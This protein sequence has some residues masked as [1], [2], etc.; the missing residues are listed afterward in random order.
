MKYKIF[1]TFFFIF[2]IYQVNILKAVSNKIIIKIENEIITN[3]EVKNKIISSLIIGNQEINQSNINKFKK[4]AVES[5]IQYKLK[6]IE[7]EN[8][9]IKH[10][11][12]KVSEYLGSI[13]SN[14]IESLKRKFIENNASFEL[15]LDEIKTE[16][17]WRQFIF[18]IYSKRINVDKE[19]IQ[20]DLNKIINQQS[21]IQEYEISEIEVVLDMKKE[22]E[23]ILFIKKQI[24]DL[25]FENAALKYSTSPSSVDEGYIGWVNAQSLSK[26]ILN[27]I[28]GLKPGQVSNP[29]S[30][31]N[32]ILILKLKNKRN[33]KA[34]N[35]DAITLEK[36][37]INQKRNELFNLYSR[38]HLSKLKNNSLIQYK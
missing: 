1:L 24:K 38:S 29:I 17:K 8:T 34:K 27:E 14:N 22:P 4:E 26:D 12:K 21:N 11:D 5:L 6:K 15:F 9:N 7:L 33:I 25:G 36:N 13:S 20:K 2:F 3:Y 35:I 23:K 28:K 10:N 18:N 32:S 19:I 31:Q 37:L 16:F 30:R